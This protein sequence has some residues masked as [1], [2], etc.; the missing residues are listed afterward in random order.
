LGGAGFLVRVVD[1]PADV[2]ELVGMIWL[3]SEQEELGREP[4]GDGRERVAHAE[5]G[6]VPV[7]C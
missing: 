5:T 7:T 1:E 2:I 6:A 3:G 4:P